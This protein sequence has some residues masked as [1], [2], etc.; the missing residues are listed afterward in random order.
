MQ[1]PAFNTVPRLLMFLGAIV[2]LLPW[3]IERFVTYTQG[4]FGGLERF[5][6]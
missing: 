5:A 3:M 1:D 2:V 6:S 4:L